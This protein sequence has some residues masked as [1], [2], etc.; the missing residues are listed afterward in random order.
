MTIGYKTTKLSKLQLTTKKRKILPPKKVASFQL[1]Q[2]KKLLFLPFDGVISDDDD[3]DDDD[4][5]DE[6]MSHRIDS[7]AYL[8]PVIKCETEVKYIYMHTDLIHLQWNTDPFDT[9]T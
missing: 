3:E 8:R 1:N 9:N 7:T 4:D 5:D 2:F 6:T